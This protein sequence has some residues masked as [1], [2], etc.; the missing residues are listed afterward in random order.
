MLNTASPQVVSC[1]ERAL[2]ARK[3]A[4]RTDD[5]SARN[6]FFACERRWLRLAQSCE[7]SERLTQFLQRPRAFAAHPVFTSRDVPTPSQGVQ[8]SLVRHPARTGKEAREFDRWRIAV[9]LVQR[10]R[11]AGIDCQLSDGFQ[12]RQ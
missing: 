3:R 2:A 12:T 8:M 6:D 7:F 4:L 5:Q 11:E 1:Y 9:E 10:L